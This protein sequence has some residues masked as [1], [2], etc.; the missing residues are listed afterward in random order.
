MGVLKIL[1]KSFKALEDFANSSTGQRLIDRAE[2]NKA[3]EIRRTTG[4]NGLSCSIDRLISNSGVVCCEGTIRNTGRSTY[5]KVVVTVEFKNSLGDTVDKR[6]T[7]V[8]P[9]GTAFYQG[10]SVPFRVLS[11]ANNLHSAQVYVSDCE[12]R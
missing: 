4:I 3:E 11:T 6:S 8:I 9:Y 12:E 1:E 2:Q 5:H 10:E 7:Y